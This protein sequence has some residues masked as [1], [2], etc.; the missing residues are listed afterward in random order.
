MFLETA[1]TNAYLITSHEQE[2][3]SMTVPLTNQDSVTSE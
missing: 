3:G 1:L 2:A